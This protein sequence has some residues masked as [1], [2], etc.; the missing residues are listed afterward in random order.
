MFD[1]D[2][3]LNVY[4]FGSH[5]YGTNDENSDE[6]YIC[7]TKKTVVSDD[8]NIHY[9]TLSEFQTLVNNCDIQAMECLFLPSEF[10]IKKSVDIEFNI[11]LTKLRENISTVTSTSYVKA[12]KKLIVMADYDKRLAIKSLF[13]S[14][15]ILDF[16]IQLARDG[17]I[18]KYDSMNYVYHDVCKMASLYSY[19]ELWEILDTKYRKIYN[20]LK[21]TF[22]TYAPK[23]TENSIEK[24]VFDVLVKNNI[25]DKYIND[26][27]VVTDIIALFNQKY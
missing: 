19:N 6:D 3:I 25:P 21:S 12:K 10:I 17:R 11:S 18:S 16:G 23:F 20:K 14:L 26:S 8:I 27:S 7:V 5:V 2:N 4:R 9:Y 22:K 24:D 15:R 1:N 13:H